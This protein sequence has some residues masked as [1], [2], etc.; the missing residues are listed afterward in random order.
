MSVINMRGLPFA[1]DLY[2]GGL[3][4]CR[5]Q[6]VTVLRDELR[7]RLL[8]DLRTAVEVPA[9]GLMSDL[10]RAGIRR[11]HSPMDGG[12]A[13]LRGRPVESPEQ[14]V[15]AYLAMIDLDAR[16][17]VG[18][19]RGL[20]GLDDGAALVAC[21]S[22]KDRTGVVAALLAGVL[23]ADDE[24]IAGDYAL[25]AGSSPEIGP[26]PPMVM[27]LF[28]AEV[29]RRHGGWDA[30]LCAMGA[31]PWLP[32]RLR[33]RYEHDSSRTARVEGVRP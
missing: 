12:T 7:I 18:C 8:V 13:V 27:R 5:D 10:D 24:A 29:R 31:E 3:A 16:S 14:L 30:C 17:L 21:R 1:R 15:L 19:L 20:A 25:S 32:A 4:S 23:G 6:D 9:D 33:A 2:R 22:G 26:C 11:L 28:C